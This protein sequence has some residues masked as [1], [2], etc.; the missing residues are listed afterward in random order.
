MAQF[1]RVLNN[2]IHWLTDVPWLED[3]E[4]QA[5]VFKDIPTT[6][7][8]L[9]IYKVSSDAE[10]ERVLIAIAAGRIKIANNLPEHEAEPG[11]PLRLHS[12]QAIL[13]PPLA[14]PFH[15]LHFRE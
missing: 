4:L 7:G 15:R 6:N 5:D 13:M 10:V 11:G 1:L 9:S 12:L 14:P 8:E 2:R 3:G